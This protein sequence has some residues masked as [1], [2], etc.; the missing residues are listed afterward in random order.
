MQIDTL[1]AKFENRLAPKKP[2]TSAKMTAA[3]LE[4]LKKGIVGLSMRVEDVEGS[5]KL[6]QQ[7]SEADYAA[8]ANGLA[9][10]PDHGSQTIAQLMRETRPQAF[11]ATTNETASLEGSM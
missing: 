10:L 9:A 1:S 2:W 7:K 4:A 6:N 5:F 3:R 11:A 8:V